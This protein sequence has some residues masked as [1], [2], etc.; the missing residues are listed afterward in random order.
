MMNCTIGEHIKKLRIEHELTLTQ[1]GGQLGID[2]GALSKI[3]NGKKL[4]DE[5]YIQGIAKIFNIDV[6]ELITE[7][8]SEKIARDII[9][10]HGQESALLLVPKKIKMLK[11][12]MTEQL[13]I[14]F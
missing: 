12:K 8:L 10:C 5:K 13:Q 2:S 4:L 7:F 1:L 9:L 3:E 11:E 6:E 14:N